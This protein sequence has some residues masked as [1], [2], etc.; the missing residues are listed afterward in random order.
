MQRF[1]FICFHR[2]NNGLE[3]DDFTL[4]ANVL[5]RTEDTVTYQRYQKFGKLQWK[6]P[7]TTTAE[8][9]TRYYQPLTDDLFIKC[10]EMEKLLCPVNERS[11]L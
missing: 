8:K 7:V 9:F 10:C 3:I 6:K 1:E 5:A 4:F 2:T 11:S